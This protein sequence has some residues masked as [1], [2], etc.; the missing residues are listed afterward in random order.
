MPDSHSTKKRHKT[1]DNF[2]KFFH[3][4]PPSPWPETK[5]NVRFI[6]H[7]A[8]FIAPIPWHLHRHLTGVNKKCRKM[9]IEKMFLIFPLPLVCGLRSS[10]FT[11]SQRAVDCNEKKKKYTKITTA[12]IQQQQRGE[13]AEKREWRKTSA[14]KKPK[15]A[16]VRDTTSNLCWAGQ[17]RSL[18]SLLFQFYSVPHCNFS[19]FSYQHRAAQWSCFLA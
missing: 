6:S 17:V 14:S 10:S 19:C 11:I 9:N 16:R 12:N 7:L 5:V 1:W 3:S 13:K 18:A 4:S 8:P 2:I 15:S